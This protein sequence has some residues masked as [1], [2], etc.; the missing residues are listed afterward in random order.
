MDDKIAGIINSE[1]SENNVTKE[2]NAL[3]TRYFI[4]LLTDCGID[5][6]E[7]LKNGTLEEDIS[8]T[9]LWDTTIPSDKRNLPEKI[10]EVCD[11]ISQIWINKYSRD[12]ASGKTELSMYSD[13]SISAMKFRIF[14]ACQVD[15]IRFTENRASASLTDK[16]VHE[17]ITIFS[18]RAEEI[19]VDKSKDYNYPVQNKDILRKIVLDLINECYLS[20][21]KKGIYG[22]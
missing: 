16:E 1:L 20:F 21:D 6:V 9:K 4:G 17:L 5:V 8:A 13:R 14:E 3:S 10:K 11:S 7:S 19:I 15:L 18:N 22:E 12:L 2:L